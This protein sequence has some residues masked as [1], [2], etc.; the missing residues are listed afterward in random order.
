MKSLPEKLP[1]FYFNN[2]LKLQEIVMFLILSLGFI[3]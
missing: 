2:T 1:E 3:G